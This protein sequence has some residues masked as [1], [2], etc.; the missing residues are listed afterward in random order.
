MFSIFNVCQIPAPQRRHT[1]IPAA[2]QSS[3]NGKK[4]TVISHGA[5]QLV[6]KPCLKEKSPFLQGEYEGAGAPS[7][8][9]ECLQKAC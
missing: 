1:R 8:W 6:E 9:I 2:P 7:Y 4:R 3:R 5:L